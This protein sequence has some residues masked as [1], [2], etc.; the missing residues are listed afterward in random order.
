[1]EIDDAYKDFI[2]DLWKAFLKVFKPVAMWLWTSLTLMLG[3][4]WFLADYLWMN[5]FTF[6]NALGATLIMV[7]ASRV[8]QGRL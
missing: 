5:Q 2:Q 4:N 8:A 6:L 1:M 7:F 3:W